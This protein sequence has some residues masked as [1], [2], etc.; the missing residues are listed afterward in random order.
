[1][2]K[3]LG[4]FIVL[5]SL[6]L[7]MSIT[8]NL[9]IF[10]DVPSVLI[11]AGVTVGGMILGYGFN[12]FKLFSLPLKQNSSLLKEHYFQIISLYQLIINLALGA[13]VLAIII[14]LVKILSNLADP[15]QIGPALAI[16]LLSAFYAVGLV[17][18][19]VLPLKHR[20]MR[21]QAIEL[22]PLEKSFLQEDSKT[23]KK[24]LSIGAVSVSIC[25]VSL[26]VFFQT[27]ELII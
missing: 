5:F 12:V 14:A 16:A 15:K 19:F 26:V 23:L 10:I 21:F 17:L 25:V 24:M 4:F 27:T 13:A 1:M 6:A 22:S 18:V 9:L 7:A 20:L 3:F 2:D 8:G 11:I